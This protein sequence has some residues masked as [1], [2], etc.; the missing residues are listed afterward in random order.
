MRHHVSDNDQG[1]GEV[2]ASFGE[3]KLIK[4]PD[5]KYELVGGTE[6]DRAEAQKWIAMF[7]RNDV[8]QGT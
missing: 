2:I 6:A 5:R 7:M 8:V 4:K 1:K 3:A